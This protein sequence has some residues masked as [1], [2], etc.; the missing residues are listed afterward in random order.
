MKNKDQPRKFKY[1]ICEDASLNFGKPSALYD[2]LQYCEESDVEPLTVKE[3]PR[4]AESRLKQ[5][6]K[7]MGNKTRSVG[8]LRQAKKVDNSK[9]F[10]KM[11]LD[12][13]LRSQH[14]EKRQITHS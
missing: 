10:Q 12:Y 8:N 7:S 3:Q 14:S 9:G 11:E 4:K 5:L 1:P 2:E 13:T 6:E